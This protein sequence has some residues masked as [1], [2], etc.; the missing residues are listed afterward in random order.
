MNPLFEQLPCQTELRTGVASLSCPSGP[1][2]SST[3]KQGQRTPSYRTHVV[4]PKEVKKVS[5]NL[6]PPE[7]PGKL[8]RTFGGSAS[9]PHV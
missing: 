1:W 8:L 9:R 7:G 5:L 2:T 3:G 4:S 6:G